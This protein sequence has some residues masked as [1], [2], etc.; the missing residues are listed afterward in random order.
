MV[1]I[2][3]MNNYFLNTSLNSSLNSRRTSLSW[4]KSRKPTKSILKK[5][6]N[7]QQKKHVSLLVR[8]ASTEPEELYEFSSFKPVSPLSENESPLTATNSPITVSNSPITEM[9]MELENLI[10]G[11]NTNTNINSPVRQ[12]K[13]TK[14]TRE[15]NDELQDLIENMSLNENINSR[16]KITVKAKKLYRLFDHCSYY[17]VSTHFTI[18]NSL[19]YYRIQRFLTNQALISVVDIYNL[20]LLIHNVIIQHKGKE[21]LTN[22]NNDFYCNAYW[23]I[24][25]TYSIT[26]LVFEKLNISKNTTITYDPNRVFFEECDIKE[27]I[28]ILRHQLSICEWLITTTGPSYRRND[29]PYELGLLVVKELKRLYEII[30][31]NNQEWLSNCIYMLC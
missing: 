29:V 18:K 14:E 31:A 19:S 21:Q 2:Q 28:H 17:D 12:T 5:P 22:E 25:L 3:S 10:I 20:P 16:N 4:D 8:H 15:I 26:N 13:E 30:D 7:E 24:Y 6:K 23:V 11:Q 1:R 27:H 9:E